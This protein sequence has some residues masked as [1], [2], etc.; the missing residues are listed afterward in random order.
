MNEHDFINDHINDLIDGIECEL[1]FNKYKELQTQH[2]T[3]RT[4]KA[5][6]LIMKRFCKELN[7]KRMA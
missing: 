1:L 6:G 2:K 7:D 4:N 3:I 5:F